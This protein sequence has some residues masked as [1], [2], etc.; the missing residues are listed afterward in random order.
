MFETPHRLH[1]AAIVIKFG[2]YF[3]ATLRSLAAPLA[4]I[5]LSGRNSSGQFIPLMIGGSI[6]VIGGVSIIGPILHYFS[7]TFFIKDDALEISSGFIWRKKRT[8]PLARIQNVNV[9]RTLWHRI[10]GAA[11]V[12]VETATGKKGEGDLTALS[13]EDANTLQAVLLHNRPTETVSEDVQKPPPLYELS[14]KQVL[15]AGALGNRAAYIIGS[16]I[17]VFQ[18]EGSHRYFRPFV[19][20]IESLGPV[21]AAVMGVLTFFGLILVGWLVSIG[22]SATRFFGFRIEQHD[23]GLLLTHGLITQFKT[24][25]PV[26]RIQDVRIVEPIL[27][28]ALGY[29]EIYADTAGSFDAKDVASANKICPILPEHEASRIGK[30]LMPEFEFERLQWQRV[31]PK[32]IFRHASRMFNMVTILLALPLGLWLHWNALWLLPPFALYCVFVG[33]ISYRYGG[34][35]WTNNIVARRHGVFRKQAIVIPFDR[36]QHYS[37]NA[38]FFQRLMGLAS[39]SAVSA[40]TGGHAIHITDMDASAA[41]ELGKTMGLSIEQHLGSRRGGL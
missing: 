16:M 26:G 32:T 29:C 11:A 27:F 1:P 37:I 2:T 30:L 21:M 4:G 23:R 24:I 41:K 5:F 36:I 22:I 9:E 40:S 3:I 25:V 8:I 35:S 20:Y 28:R 12:K 18:F 38:S 39:V 31:S 10:L 17:A 33:L 15:L 19:H 6:A 14:P 13:L 34:Y 7:T